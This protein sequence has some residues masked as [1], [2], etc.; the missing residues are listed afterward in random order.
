M[1]GLRDDAVVAALPIATLLRP[2]GRAAL[3]RGGWHQLASQPT[4]ADGPHHTDP[5]RPA[6]W[7]ILTMDRRASAV[8]TG[9]HAGRSGTVD[10]EAMGSVA[11]V[12]STGSRPLRRD[13]VTDLVRVAVGGI[14]ALGP[15]G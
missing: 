8:F 13:E 9:I 4:R 5:R 1:V 12:Y 7:P 6:S 14:E 11:A 10:A 2:A 15:F 3:L